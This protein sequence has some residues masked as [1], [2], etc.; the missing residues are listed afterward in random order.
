MKKF[1]L[2][3]LLLSILIACDGNLKTSQAGLDPAIESKIDSI[4]AQMTIEEKVGQMSQ[5]TVD[6]IGKGGNAFTSSEP[7]EIDP[8]MLDTVIGK[9][10]VGSI[11]NTSNNRARTTEV[12]EKTIQTIQER[13]IKE[14][15]I[16]VI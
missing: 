10:K 9:Y 14:T 4:I 5:F 1:S 3:I 13:A 16:P 12:W 6:L 7:F 2:W 8:A 11:L 15:G